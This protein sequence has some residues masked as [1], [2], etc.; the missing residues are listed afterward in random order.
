MIRL[1]TARCRDLKEENFWNL[2]VLRSDSLH[3][4]VVTLALSTPLGTLG[5]LALS[6]NVSSAWGGGYS[7]VS[8]EIL[9]H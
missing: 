8:Q 7:L 4:F 3:L 1:A 6:V 9:G 5:S 2:S